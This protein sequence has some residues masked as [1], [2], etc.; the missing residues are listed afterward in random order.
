MLR[1]TWLNERWLFLIKKKYPHRA[2]YFICELMLNF[3]CI[4]IKNKIVHTHTWKTVPLYITMEII[5]KSGKLIL[6]SQLIWKAYQA[7]WYWQSICFF[8]GNVQ[9]VPKFKSYETDVSG[10]LRTAKWAA[11]QILSPNKSTEIGQ[12]CLKRSSWD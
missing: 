2:K 6:L 9:A 3:P 10:T 12:N 1:D 4:G 7:I 8:W 11:W 5:I